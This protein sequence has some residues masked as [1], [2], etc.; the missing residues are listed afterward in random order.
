MLNVKVAELTAFQLLFTESFNVTR[1]RCTPYNYTEITKDSMKKTNVSIIYCKFNTIY[2]VTQACNST[3]LTMC[4]VV[5][6]KR[7]KV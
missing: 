3:I 4:I 7:S 2:L 5:I 6:M 1:V